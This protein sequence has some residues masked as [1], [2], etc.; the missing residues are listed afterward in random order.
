[1]PDQEHIDYENVL[2]LSPHFDDVPLSL[3]E[4]LRSGWLSTTNVDVRVIF[5]ATNWTTHLY[6]T[7]SRAPLVSKWR[8]IE[9]NI[10]G[11]LFGY[12]WWAAGWQE[13]VLRLDTMDSAEFLD[14]QIDVASDPLTQEIAEWLYTVVTAPLSG[15][16]PD[17]VLAPAGMGNHLDHRIV[18]AAALRVM[19]R[20]D[21]P[22][23]LYEDRPYCSYLSSNERMAFVDKLSDV[24]ETRVE[25]SSTIRRST[26]RRVQAS[27]FSQMTSYFDE[28]MAHDLEQGESEVLWWPEGQA[29]PRGL[30]PS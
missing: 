8:R 30:T 15:N 22:I 28:A 14:P 25:V 24:H 12:N 4:S 17:V 29:L 5:G 21:V 10:A 23:A 7:A 2:V 11:A 18:S 9:E 6:P 20:V 13:V 16:L 3:G 1:M 19:P 27:Y 26:Q